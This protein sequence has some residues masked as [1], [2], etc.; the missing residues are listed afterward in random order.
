[1]K[2]TVCIGLGLVPLTEVNK[3]EFYTIDIKDTFKSKKIGTLSV[4]IDF[5]NEDQPF[6]KDLIDQ[7]IEKYL[8]NLVDKMFEVQETKLP[9]AEGPEFQSSQF[10]VMIQ[11]H[12]THDAR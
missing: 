10:G 2:D 12:K 3:D 4:K 6:Y 9:E 7:K 5:L 11:E 1:M 8:H